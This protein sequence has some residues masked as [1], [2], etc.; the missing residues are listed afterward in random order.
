[1]AAVISIRSTLS[2]STLRIACYNRKGWEKCGAV[3]VGLGL[4]LVADGFQAGDVLL[5]GRV[6][7][8]GDTAFDG[9]VKALEPRIG[10]GGALVQFGD[11]LAPTLGALLA[12]VKHRSQ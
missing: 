7:K 3:G 5:Q 4:G 11:V 10:F 1:M 12:A 8:V 9:V 6:I 2:P